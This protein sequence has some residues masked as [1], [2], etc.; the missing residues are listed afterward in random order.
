VSLRKLECV[1][2]PAGRRSGEQARAEE[3]R[4]PRIS[5]RPDARLSSIV[6]GGD[7]GYDQDSSPRGDFVIPASVTT[8]LVVKVEDSPLRPPVFVL[9]PSGSFTRVSG[10]CA[11]AYIEMRLAPI[12][13]YTVL[14]PAVAEVGGTI[15]GLDDLLG[16]DARRLGERIRSATTWDE[17]FR[18]LDAFVVDRCARGPE[19]SPEVREAWERLEQSGGTGTIGEIAGEVGWS[20]KHLI[21]KFKQQV[22][23][24][25]RLA[26]RLLRLARVWRLI[27]S[28]Q[29]WARIAAESGYADQ[30]HLVREFR[31]FT[32]TTPGA[33]ITG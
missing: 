10:R 31:Q 29:S 14:G 7:D 25:P 24:A 9:G 5:Y 6:A 2:H 20:H 1:A 8:T 4:R 33:L 26:A 16:A 28:D 11:P 27:E 30:S 13:A 3:A 18:L 23:V 12:G 21:T 17:R 32:G 19:P 15:A 22:G